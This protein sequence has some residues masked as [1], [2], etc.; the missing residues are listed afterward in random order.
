MLKAFATKGIHGHARSVGK[1]G[2][3]EICLTFEA[4]HS[5]QHVVREADFTQLAVADHVESDLLL[6]RHHLSNRL[7]NARIERGLIDPLAVLDVVHELRKIVGSRKASGMSRQNVF[8]AQL[9]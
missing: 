7:A 6:A 4:G 2:G 9:H 3:H 8:G 5:L 1:I